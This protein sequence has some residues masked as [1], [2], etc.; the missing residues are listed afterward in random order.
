[1]VSNTTTSS[2]PMHTNEVRCSRY[3]P[4]PLSARSPIDSVGSPSAHPWALPLP[5]GSS[6]AHF[7]LRSARRQSVPSSARRSDHVLAVGRAAFP[8]R[9]Q[10][11][12]VS[13]WTHHTIPDR[14]PSV[15]RSDAFEQAG[16]GHSAC[17]V[18]PWLEDVQAAVL[19]KGRHLRS[20][21]RRGRVVRVAI[22]VVPGATLVSPPLAR[23]TLGDSTFS[24][25][26]NPGRQAECGRAT[27]HGM[28]ALPLRA[29]PAVTSAGGRARC[30]RSTAA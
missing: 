13:S 6:Y 20:T 28:A 25:R 17:R 15:R 18:S 3:G 11:T 27:A 22:N 4:T 2:R 29:K 14:G 16:L 30:A 26:R 12:R 9:H 5:P 24:W 23:Q 8:R 19:T 1:L 7:G 21:N 10:G